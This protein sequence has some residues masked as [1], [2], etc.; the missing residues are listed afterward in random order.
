MKKQLALAGAMLC[1]AVPSHAVL[2]EFTWTFDS[3]EVVRGEFIALGVDGDGFLILGSG[4]DSWSVDFMDGMGPIDQDPRWLSSGEENDMGDISGHAEIPADG[5]VD[6][7]VLFALYDDNPAWI[8]EWDSYFT[9]A[10]GQ[11]QYH[12]TGD[13]GYLEG[14]PP[15]IV[16]PGA[17]R[18]ISGPGT[19]SLVNLNATPS[20][21]PDSGG[22]FALGLLALGATIRLRRRHP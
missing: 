4:L 8:V 9:I 14:P 19:W 11:G 18:A 13:K 6:R 15:I 5:S 7:L 21:V 17:P 1:M 2:Y 3:G 22:S 16:P 12:E 10:L 20:S